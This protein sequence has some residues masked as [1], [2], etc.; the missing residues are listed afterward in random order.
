[1]VCVCVCVCVCACPHIP[2]FV[3]ALQGACEL[4]AE[5]FT[6]GLCVLSGAGL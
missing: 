5:S 2:V 4:T 1:V 3:A 6:Q